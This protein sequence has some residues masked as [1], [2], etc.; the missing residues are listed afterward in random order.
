M[1]WLA[2]SVKREGAVATEVDVVQVGLEDLALRITRVQD[3]SHER[4]DD[5]ALVGALARQ[6]VVLHELLRECRATLSDPAALHVAKHRAEDAER[7]DTGVP[8]EANV[9]RHDD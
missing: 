1:R 9:F 5:F 7:V 8:P 6:V 2:D 4:F 3:E